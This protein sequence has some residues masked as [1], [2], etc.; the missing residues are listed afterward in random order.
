MSARRFTARSS[1]QPELAGW[2]PDALPAQAWV[3]THN[4]RVIPAKPDQIWA[5]LVR[6]GDWPTWYSNARRV[7]LPSG[8]A[9]L[10]AGTTFRWTTFLVRLTSR[11]TVFE[12]PVA[13][14]WRWRC[15]GAWGYHGWRLDPHP[16]GT[17]V[18]TEESQHG[19]LPC[20]TRTF[21][22]FLLSKSHDMWLRQLAERTVHRRP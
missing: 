5:E 15:P 12:P 14:G 7:R 2:P 19:T 21:M 22:R 13:I 18:V 8:A 4:E 6:A 20:L 11:V 16:S 17:R 1:V 3:F 10:D 9:L